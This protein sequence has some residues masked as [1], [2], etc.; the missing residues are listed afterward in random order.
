MGSDESA[1]LLIGFGNVY[2]SIFLCISLIHGGFDGKPR[3]SQ[4]NVGF[5]EYFGTKIIFEL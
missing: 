1:N 4:N 5:D 3:H 2:K